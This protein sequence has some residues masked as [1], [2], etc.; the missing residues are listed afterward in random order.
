M[1]LNKQVDNDAKAILTVEAVLERLI[2][3]LQNSDE[4]RSTNMGNYSAP[5]IR[6]AVTN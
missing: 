3:T 5:L 2:S 4:M 1:L 6:V